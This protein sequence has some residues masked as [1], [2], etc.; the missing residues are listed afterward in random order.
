VRLHIAHDHVFESAIFTNCGDM[1]PTKDN[2]LSPSELANMFQTNQIAIKTY[3]SK[4]LISVSP[5]NPDSKVF[6]PLDQ[7][8]LKFIINA[9][10]ADYSIGSIAKLIGEL[11]ENKQASD[12]LDECMV[13][14]KKVYNQLEESLNDLDMLEQVNVTCDMELLSVYLNELNALK[15]GLHD[16]SSNDRIEDP[17]SI[18]ISESPISTPQKRISVNNSVAKDLPVKTLGK[19]RVKKLL[20]ACAFFLILII[21]GYSYFDQSAILKDQVGETD[22]IESSGSDGSLNDDSISYSDPRDPT[23]EFT[24]A[25]D[26]NLPQLEADE[27]ENLASVKNILDLD[28][29]ETVTAEQQVNSGKYSDPNISEN[30]DALDPADTPSEAESAKK[31]EDELFKKLVSDLTAKYDRQT[32]TKQQRQKSN[33]ELA[34]LDTN[35]SKK[36]TSDKTNPAAKSPNNSSTSPQKD[37]KAD[38]SP[39]DFSVFAGTTAMDRK[40]KPQTPASKTSLKKISKVKPTDAAPKK[41]KQVAQKPTIATKPADTTVKAP[42][43]T[44]QTKTSPSTESD[45]LARKST[46]PAVKIDSAVSKEDEAPS[47]VKAIPDSKQTPSPRTTNPEALKWVQKSYESVLSGNASEAI[48]TA[49]VAITLDPGSVNAYI[50]RSWAYSKKGLFDKAIQDCNKALELDAKN[51]LANNNRGL[52]FQGKGNLDKAKQDYQQACQLGLKVGCNNYQE[53]LG[54]LA[55]TP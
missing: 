46:A 4:K 19:S 6:S 27:F 13:Y 10:N 20:Y 55:A 2:Y 22:S 28:E 18:K 32:T 5:S 3:T 34:L 1:K 26:E 31:L 35:S 9:K 39:N 45:T 7:I 25:I 43:V 8:R 54:I 50:N 17:G 53:V 49:S 11:D 24:S 23:N 29:N 47:T 40:E 42:V 44:I 30:I 36:K 14:G 52:A 38:D 16:I 21:F 37:N 48:V 51:A 33:Q 12:Q 41:P 15:Y